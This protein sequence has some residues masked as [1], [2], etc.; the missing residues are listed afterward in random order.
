MGRLAMVDP[1][2]TP[3]VGI[4]QLLSLLASE[5]EQLAYER[6]V[7]IADVPAELLCLWF[8]DTYHP[9]F[10][11][12]AYFADRELEALACF[13]A[14]YGRQKKRLPTSCGTIRT[15]LA[16]PV[17]RE[18]MSAAAETLTEIPEQAG[19]IQEVP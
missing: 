7:P 17:W 5:E 4:R 6:D 13:N 8:D 18:V 9:D 12:R 19:E 11:W 2:Y 14:L 15:W 10:G 3:R 1:A 16:S